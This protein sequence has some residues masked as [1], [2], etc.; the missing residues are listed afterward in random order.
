VSALGLLWPFGVSAEAVEAGARKA[1]RCIRCH[2]AKGVSE[3][4]LVPNLAG[5]KQGYL[6]EQLKS[7]REGLRRSTPM[8]QVTQKLTDEDIEDLA[9]YYSQLK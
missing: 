7:F 2:G 1:E 9:A 6:V 4:P 3:A 5:Q 8:R